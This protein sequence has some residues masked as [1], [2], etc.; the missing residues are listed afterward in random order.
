MTATVIR[1]R[2]RSAVR[3][4]GK[5][6]GLSLDRIDAL[7]KIVDGRSGD[8]GLA[9]KC[10][11]IGLDPASETGKRFLYLVQNLVGFLAIYPNTSVGW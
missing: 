3:D 5:A 8:D 6:I 10:A 9:A 11:Q 7:S 2:I 1:Y 4:C